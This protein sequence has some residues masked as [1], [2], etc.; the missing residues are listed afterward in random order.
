[1]AYIGNNNGIGFVPA[2]GSITQNMFAA[3]LVLGGGSYAGD[4]GGGAGDIFRI[5]QAE[6]NTNVTIAATNNA[7]CAG[8]LTLATGVTVTVNGNLVIA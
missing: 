3:G 8:P 2:A 6:L 1:M 7:L 5:H 4:S